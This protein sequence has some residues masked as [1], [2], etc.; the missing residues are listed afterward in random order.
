MDTMKWIQLAT[1]KDKT[2]FNLGSI[3]RA[4]NC[5]VATDGHRLHMSN[6]LIDA[7]P[8]YLDG[9]DAD[10]P[11]FTKIMPTGRAINSVNIFEGNIPSLK[12]MLALIKGRHE[13]NAVTLEVIKPLTDH[14]A[15]IGT[16]SYKDEEL[17]VKLVLQIGELVGSSFSVSLNLAYFIDAIS[18]P[19]LVNLEYR[20]KIDPILIKNFEQTAIIMPLRENK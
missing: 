16:V 7:T 1:S 4:K 17:E 3:Y 15:P 14:E 9:L 13:S 19:T 20:S 8:H 2:R 10:F 12:R 11:D 6:G 5:L 18:L